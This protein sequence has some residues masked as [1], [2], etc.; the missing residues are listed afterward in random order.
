M[1]YSKPALDVPAQISLLENRGLV[2][3]DRTRAA[4]YLANIG[5]YRLRAYTY[6]FQNIQDPGHPFK[7][8]VSFE[9]VISLYVF[10]RRLRLLLLNALEK[11]EV[12]FRA[13]IIFNWATAHGSHWC[14]I[15]SLYRDSTRFQKDINQ[16]H[17]EIDRSKEA[18]IVDYKNKYTQPMYPPCWMS[19]EVASFGL[20]SRIFENLAK[21]NAKNNVTRGFGLQNYDVMESWMHAFAALRNLCAHHSRIWNRTFVI[22]PRK[23][24]NPI[25]DF[26]I[27]TKVGSDKLY[28]QLSGIAYI[29]H[30]ISPGHDFIHRLKD[31]FKET[32]IVNSS[33][34]GFPQDW[35]NE[36][37]W[38]KNSV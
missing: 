37:L 32:P 9:D 14:E 10:D 5:Y 1:L 34:I 20:L 23:L 28:Y 24:A 12:A 22:T 16:L 6:P 33:D 4:D 18:F 29:L 21:G 26:L 31:L 35:E 15:L 3:Q 19:L 27:N 2:I 17:D 7:E 11:I 13:K 30:I 36:P 8:G 38:K 25:H